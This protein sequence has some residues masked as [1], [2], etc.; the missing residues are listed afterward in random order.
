MSRKKTAISVL[1]DERIEELGALIEIVEGEFDATTHFNLSKFKIDNPSLSNSISTILIKNNWARFV[2]RVTNA[3]SHNILATIKSCTQVC[4]IIAA[5]NLAKGTPIYN[6]PAEYKGFP[7]LINYGT[8]KPSSYEAYCSY[9]PLKPGIS[10]SDSE[11]NGVCTLGAIFKEKRQPNKK[12]LLT[13]RHGVGD[14]DGIIIKPGKD[15]YENRLCI[16]EVDEW[17]DKLISNRQCR[18]NTII[19]D[20]K[21]NIDTQIENIGT[22]CVQKIV[23]TWQRGIV[24]NLFNGEVEVEVLIVTGDHGKFGDHGDSGSPVY[25]DNGTLW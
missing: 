23:T 1:N 10:I 24:N 4:R 8:I 18:T 20:I 5:V 15:T 17:I 13:V 22:V 16:C 14:T 21:S 9:Q 3:I 19:N 7:V 6:V 11:I 12:Y 2:D 25:D